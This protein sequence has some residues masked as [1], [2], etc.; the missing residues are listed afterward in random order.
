MSENMI[1]LRNGKD[2]SLLRSKRLRL[3][4]SRWPRIRP[5]VVPPTGVEVGPGPPDVSLVFV[6]VLAGDVKMMDN[7][8]SAVGVYVL[9]VAKRAIWPRTAGLSLPPAT[10]KNRS[11]LNRKH[12]VLDILLRNRSYIRICFKMVG[13]IICFKFDNLG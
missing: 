4:T 9:N 13:T 3:R 5:R 7:M 1:F 2:G 6:A 11:R 8:L 12:K 10:I